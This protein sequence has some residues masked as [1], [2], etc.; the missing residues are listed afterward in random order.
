MGTV[1]QR[2][3][4]YNDDIMRC[5]KVYMH[6][7]TIPCTTLGKLY[8]VVKVLGSNGFN[9]TDDVDDSLSFNFDNRLA[10]EYFEKAT[11]YE[12]KYMYRLD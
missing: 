1:I 4:I 11:D 2:G 7:K 6:D 8:S 10:T 3:N 5:I 9:V 12:L